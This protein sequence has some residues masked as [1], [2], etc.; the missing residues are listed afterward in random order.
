M[1]KNSRKSIRA[2]TIQ[3]K[4]KEKPK[5]VTFGDATTTSIISTL[6]ALLASATGSVDS[7]AA[8]SI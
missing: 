2:L 3:F 6:V 7:S 5:F 8:V 4:V 1:I